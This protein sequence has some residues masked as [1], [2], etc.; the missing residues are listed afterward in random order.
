MVLALASFAS[1]ARAQTTDAQTTDAQTTDA[2]TSG[3]QPADADAPGAT[4]DEQSEP[5]TTPVPEWR[6]PGVIVWEIGLRLYLPPETGFDRALIGHGYDKLGLVPGL[7][8]SFAIPAGVEWLWLGGQLGVRGRT[9]SHAEHEDASMVAADLLAMVRVRFL[10]GDRVELGAAVGGGLGWAGVWVNGVM[11][12]QVVPRFTVQGDLS[13]RIG[14]HFAFGPRVGWDYLQQQGLNTYG[15]SADAG[16][17]YFGL[18][19]EGRE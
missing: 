6:W 1:T 13:F 7:V 16:G 2:P 4:P 9:W 3:A 15:H 18:S 17:P 8:A 19:L 5:P 10:L 11:S 14:R 12:D